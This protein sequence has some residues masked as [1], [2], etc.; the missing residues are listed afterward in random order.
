M[1]NIKFTISTMFK[2]AVSGIKDIHVV[3][4]PSPLSISRTF[5]SFQTETL[6]PL[7]PPPEPHDQNS[8]FF[9]SK[10]DYFRYLM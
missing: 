2:F 8:T 10:F 4:Q 5:S 7:L 1:Q 3:G 6:S 9:S